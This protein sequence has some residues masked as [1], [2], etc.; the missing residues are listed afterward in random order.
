MQR[1]AERLGRWPRTIAVRHVEFADVLAPA[2]PGSGCDLVVSPRL[3]GLDE[4]AESLL[5]HLVGAPDWPPRGEPDTWDAWGF[6]REL[7]I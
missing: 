6:P 4:A 3:A 7:V 1:A 5:E 2:I